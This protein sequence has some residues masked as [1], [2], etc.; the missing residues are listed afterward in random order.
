MT[1][2]RGPT[3]Q[4]SATRTSCGP[5]P[6]GLPPRNKGIQETKYAKITN[7]QLKKFSLKHT[8]DVIAARPIKQPKP[9]NLE[10]RPVKMEASRSHDSA[11]TGGLHSKGSLS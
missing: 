4:T 3:Q 10:G 2:F 1:A 11:P 6:T 8:S 5:W 7:L 9:A